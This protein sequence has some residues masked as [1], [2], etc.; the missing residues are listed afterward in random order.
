MEIAFECLIES[1]LDDEY[2]I[3]LALRARLPEL[4]WDEGDSSW[5]KVRVWGKSAKCGINVYRY[6]SPGPFLLTITLASE[7]YPANEIELAYYA[8]RVRVLE[9]LQASIFERHPPPQFPLIQPGGRFP[10]AYDFERDLSLMDISRVLAGRIELWHW[11]LRWHTEEGRRGKELRFDS[12]DGR[13]PFRRGGVLVFDATQQIRIAGVRPRYSLHAGRWS[14]EPG[15]EP[16]CAQVHEIVQRVV[17]PTLN[18]KN[19]RPSA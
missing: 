11:Q 9:A 4:T 2:K 18:A 1:P 16:T 17:L 12:V 6:E 13:I 8:L 14:D 5:D 7:A 15:C 19:V 10:A 3:L